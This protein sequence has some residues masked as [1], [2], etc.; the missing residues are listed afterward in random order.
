MRDQP[1]STSVR[2]TT[3]WFIKDR[4]LT[5]KSVT[6]S[7]PQR[8]PVGL[9]LKDRIV[10]ISEDRFVFEAY[11]G[12]GDTKGKQEVKVRRKRDLYG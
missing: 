8:V 12:Y 4:I 3:Q 9:E 1:E 2:I 5:L 11:E 7:D 6:S 10:S